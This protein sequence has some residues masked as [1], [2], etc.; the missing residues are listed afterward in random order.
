MVTR[1]KRFPDDIGHLG[2]A[3]R[4]LADVGSSVVCVLIDEVEVVGDADEQPAVAGDGDDGAVAEDR[5]DG[6]ALEAED[7]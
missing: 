5:V 1:L 6:S 7:G 4:S 2:A 3:C